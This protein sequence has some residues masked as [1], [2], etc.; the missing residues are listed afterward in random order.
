MEK[1]FLISINLLLVQLASAASYTEM[2]SP[3]TETMVGL[4]TYGSH[5]SISVGNSGQIAHT[6]NGVS[7]LVDSGLTTDLFD[8]HIVDEN[9]AVASGMDYV[10]FWNGSAW[11][12]IVDNSANSPSFITPVWA[13]PK[14][15]TIYYQYLSSG[16][17]SYLCPYSV[18]NPNNSG[19]C[20]GFSKPILTFC[21]I[22]GDIKALQ[23]NGSIVRF[24]QGTLSNLDV[25]LDEPVFI[26]PAAS[27]LNL[28]AAYIPENACVAGNIAPTEIFAIH[29]SFGSGPNEFYH[30]DGNTWSS[31]A[32]AGANQ[33]LTG[34]EGVNASKIFAVGKQDNGG[35]NSGVVWLYNGTNWQQETLPA[36]TPGLANISIHVEQYDVIFLN[37][38]ETAANKKGAF[39]TGAIYAIIIGECVDSLCKI[40]TSDFSNEFPNADLKVDKTLVDPIPPLSDANNVAVNDIITYAIKVTNLGRDTVNSAILNDIYF[41][42]QLEYI[43]SSLDCQPSLTTQGNKK[44]LSFALTNLAKGDFIVCRPKFK[45]L[46]I[47]TQSSGAVGVLNVVEV[48]GNIIDP[49]LDNNHDACLIDSNMANQP[50]NRVQ[51]DPEKIWYLLS[52]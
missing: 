20:K 14:K 41:S 52:P 2:P 12:T 44:N 8:V 42:D 22:A 25:P 24:T 19:F 30:F 33:T 34:I 37:S 13:S 49:N 31:M 39:D 5:F 16:P 18:N 50:A 17:F 6:V 10:L 35:T 46:S 23:T 21:G 1:Q 40:L 51:C 27:A 28:I 7:S 3:A 26:Q 32:T 11:S 48:K 9:F 38:F 45:V 47:P 15:D 36:N 4:D 29:Q 43:P